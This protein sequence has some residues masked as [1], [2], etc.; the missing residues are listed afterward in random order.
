MVVSEH[1]QEP[2]AKPATP[3]TASNWPRGPRPARHVRV[4]HMHPHAPCARARSN[5]CCSWRCCSRCTRR[6]ELPAFGPAVIA[7][8]AHR[9][10]RRAAASVLP[11]AGRGIG[12]R[13]ATRG[14]IVPFTTAGAAGAALQRRPAWVLK[15]APFALAAA[16]GN[17]R[18]GP[19]G[20]A[21]RRGRPSRRPGD[22]DAP[23]IWRASPGPRYRSSMRLVYAGLPGPLNGRSCAV[24]SAAGQGQRQ[25]PGPVAQAP[26]PLHLAPYL[27]EFA[28]ARHPVRICIR[29]IS[30]QIR[31]DTRPHGTTLACTALQHG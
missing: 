26:P 13:P 28:A 22:A 1:T 18:L 11:R 23:W 27:S 31:S 16:P 29:F 21:L 19:D 20:S 10:G 25:R 9:R 24:P 8:S 12:S 2:P 7:D 4:G 5:S 6:V 30:S 14:Y 17:G 15:I 3:A